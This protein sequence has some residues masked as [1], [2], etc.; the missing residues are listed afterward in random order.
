MQNDINNISFKNVL[1]KYL[2][3]KNKYIQLG[4]DDHDVGAGGAGSAAGGAGGT[5]ES[6]GVEDT[7][8][9]GGPGFD[10]FSSLVPIM[11]RQISEDRV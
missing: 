8:H 3:Y 7:V 1:L 6:K 2:K 11:R 5:S 4:G 10:P 9:V